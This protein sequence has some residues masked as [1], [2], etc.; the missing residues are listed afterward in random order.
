M[1]MGLIPGIVFAF[2][3]VLSLV[4]CILVSLVGRRNVVA[5]TAQ[6]SVRSAITLVLFFAF[7]ASALIALITGFGMLR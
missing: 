3:S 2:A 5:G 6:E 1:P 4:A 7:F